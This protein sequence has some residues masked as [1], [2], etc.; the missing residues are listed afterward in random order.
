MAGGI[1]PIAKHR[2]TIYFLFGREVNDKKWS[3]F[4][5]RG[6]RH[7]KYLETAIREGT[8]ELDGFLGTEQNLKKLILK[9]HILTVHNNKYAT[10]IFEINYDPNL[11]LYFNNHHKFIKKN[12]P[13][14]IA[15]KGYFEKSE[16]S[17]ISLNDLQKL[18]GKFRNFYQST[19]DYIISQKHKIENRL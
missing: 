15:H 10:I 12:F 2:G 1:L 7:E 11:P 19:I 17:W 4:G 3:D 18:R 6:E 5:G 16:I 13:H 14:L 9:N 8:E